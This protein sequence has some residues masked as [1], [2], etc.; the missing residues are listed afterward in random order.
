MA[1]KHNTLAE[2][3]Q[4][5]WELERERWSKMSGTGIFLGVLVWVSYFTWMQS[6]FQLVWPRVQPH[7]HRIIP[8]TQPS[9]Y[10]C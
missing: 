2:R 10:S 5:A 7:F 1:P 4:W 8:T 3:L 9:P 6:L